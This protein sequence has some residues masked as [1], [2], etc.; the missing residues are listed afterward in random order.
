MYRR[1]WHAWI[2]VARGLQGQTQQGLGGGHAHRPATHLPHALNSIFL[3]AQ[4][5]ES[6]THAQ[7]P[8]STT[9]ATKLW[10]TFLQRVNPIVKLSFPWTLDRLQSALTDA[11]HYERLT[12]GE[13]ALAIVS[14]YFGVISL[15]R[16]ECVEG[17]GKSK[18]DLIADYQLHCDKCFMQLN[19]LAIDDIESLKALCLYIVR[20][21]FQGE[22]LLH[23]DS[24]TAG[25]CRT[26]AST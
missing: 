22:A 10:A 19:L 12:P 4:L 23:D 17:F 20:L 1:G 3:P 9:N 16:E 15:S 13:R 6:E 24:N 5:P 8:F 11:H 14:C 21:Y 25:S 18:A 7:L 2:N 26:Q